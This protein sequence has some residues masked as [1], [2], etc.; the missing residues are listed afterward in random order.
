MATARLGGFSPTLGFVA[1]VAGALAFAIF[2][3]SRYL[4]AGADSTITPIF[5]GALAALAAAGSPAY[6]EAAATLAVLVGALLMLASLLRAGWVADLLSLP[7]MTGFLAGVSVHIAISQAPA[8]LGLAEEKGAIFRR[9]VALAAGL[10]QANPYTLALG[11]GALAVIAICEKLSRRLPGA[12][13]ALIAATVATAH[14]S[15]EEKGVAVLGVLSAEPPHFALRG[16]DPDELA[17]LAGLAALIAV[18]VMVQTATTSRSFPDRAGAV[19]DVDRDFLGLGAGCIL[20]GCL[21]AFPVNASPP[22]T[23]IVADTGGRTQCVGLFAAA[24]VVAVAAFGAKALAAAPQAAL[25]GVLLFVAA[26]IFRLGALIDLLRRTR[27]EFALALATLVGVVI[28]PMQT[29]VALAIILSLLHGVWTITRA[30]LIRFERLPG[31]TVWWPQEPLPRGET[32]PGVLVAGF[33]APLSFLNAQ[34]FRRDLLAAIEASAEP[35]KLLVLEASSIVEVDYTA[36]KALVELLE[37]CRAR[38]VVVAL[39]RLESLRAAEALRN[40]GVLDALGEGRLFHSVDEATR[41]LA[42]AA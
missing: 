38:G 32:L 7:V 13:I 21:G 20:S 23:A 17:R 31:T 25:A 10:P 41:A 5:A 1:F 15:L 16:L 39:A 24:A 19:A 28:L 3:A 14:W 26:R 2:G 34:L 8:L 4:S 27:A 22:R 18:I 29:G 30:R 11:L 9:C 6:V 42:P 12:L 33:Q 36:A 35:P 40:F 37:A